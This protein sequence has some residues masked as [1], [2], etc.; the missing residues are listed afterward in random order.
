MTRMTRS[1]TSAEAETEASA[2]AESRLAAFAQHLR[3]RLRRSPRTVAAYRDVLARYFSHAGRLDTTP[4]DLRAFLRDAS[5]RLAPA[6]QSLFASALRVYLRW[7][8][9]EGESTAA[10]LR[11]VEAPR[12]PRPLMRVVD[13]E[14]L[15]FL[16]QHIATRPPEE[17]LLFELLYGSALRISEARNLDFESLD[18]ARSE[19]RVRGKGDRLRRVP[20]TEAARALLATEGQAS[21]FRQDW[22][23]RDVRTLRRWVEAWGFSALL[24]DKYEGHLHPHQ[25]RH[26]LATHLLKRGAS[27]RHIQKWLGHERLTTTERYTHLDTQALVAAYDQ[28]FPLAQRHKDPKK[29]SEE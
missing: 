23:A 27:L 12:V 21:K 1:L 24:S 19:A 15:T 6:S 4:D 8:E 16:L 25:L 10:A 3:V 13:E 20:L 11:A 7:R 26:S 29:A 5:K 2:A 17:R 22:H 28:A 18:L 14:D 9:S